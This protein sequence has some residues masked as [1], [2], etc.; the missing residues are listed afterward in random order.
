MS[1]RSVQL[2]VTRGHKQMAVSVLFWLPRRHAP[3][4][5]ALWRNMW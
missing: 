5:L 4:R 2:A 1:G 3:A